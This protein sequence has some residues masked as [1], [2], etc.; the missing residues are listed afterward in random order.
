MRGV[1]L[2]LPVDLKVTERE[3]MRVAAAL[4]RDAGAVADVAVRAVAAD[5]VAR[6]HVLD[7]P[8]AVAKRAGDV[9]LAG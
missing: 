2:E 7:A 6:A 5:Q 1:A 9:L 8:V 3:C 4:E